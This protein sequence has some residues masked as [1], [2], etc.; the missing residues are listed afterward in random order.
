MKVTKVGKQPL[1][2]FNSPIDIGG[3]KMT[4][5]GDGKSIDEQTND[6]LIDRRKR[7]LEEAK[8]AEL[9]RATEEE[10]TEAAR[11]RKEREQ[12]E[13]GKGNPKGEEVNV[14][15]VTK[16]VEEAAA[17]AAEAAGAG[18]DPAKAAELATGKSKVVVIEKVAEGAKA[19]EDVLRE[20]AEVIEQAKA[21][22]C[23]CIDAGGD[24]KQCANMVAGLIPSQPG[25]SSPP[26]TSITELVTALKTL[27]ELRSGDRGMS[28]LKTSFDN[29]AAEIRQGGGKGNQPLDPV[30]FAKQQAEALKEW[31]KVIT[32]IAPPPSA[33]GESLEVV[34][35][36]NRHNEAMETIKD[37]REYKD[38]ITE[39]AG[40]I[41]EKIGE[42]IASRHKKG[43]AAADS[44]GGLDHMICT[45][46]DCGTPIFYTPESKTITCPKCGTVYDREEK[47]E[48]ASE[49]AE[50]TALRGG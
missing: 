44:G 8:E 18:V 1:R 2:K 34:K 16:Q 26:V 36:K 24:A 29:L 4:N 12:I 46:K 28:E 43:G 45:E 31:H 9:G 23:S 49:T 14:E 17:V 47:S 10:K 22:Y 25:A 41:P 27:D 40:S 5:T 50:E 20:R 7:K 15:N 48:A 35:E 32:E 37:E 6:Y 13:S 3:I 39:I 21:L 38:N 30:S 33:S 11:L 19:A 42:G